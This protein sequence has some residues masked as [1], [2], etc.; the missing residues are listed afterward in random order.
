MPEN[1]VEQLR[2]STEN[3][4]AR[5]QSEK[6]EEQREE[7]KRNRQEKRRLRSEVKQFVGQQFEAR[8]GEVTQHAEQA[9][10]NGQTEAKTIWRIRRGERDPEPTEELAKFRAL[11]GVVAKH[12]T[13]LNFT[14]D[15]ID[16]R[17]GY[18]DDTYAQSDPD[19]GWRPFI[20]TDHLIGVELS[21]GEEH[22]E[23]K[24]LQ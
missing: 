4:I 7:A 16:S 6:A 1:L 12:F 17:D 19:G 15:E 11:R 21:W 2:S 10:D 9:A 23:N 18:E 14:V 5:R 13:D 8:V 24:L 20:A 22:P 3:A